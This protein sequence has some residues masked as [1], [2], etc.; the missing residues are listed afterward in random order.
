MGF[1]LTYILY[2]NLIFKK[3]LMFLRYWIEVKQILVIQK[4]GKVLTF[5]P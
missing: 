1:L 4:I 2:N 3:T 5:V